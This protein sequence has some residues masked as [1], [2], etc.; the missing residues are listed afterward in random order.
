MAVVIGGAILA[1][2]IG[3][4]HAPFV[5]DDFSSITANRSIRSLV[6]IRDVLIYGHDE[7]RTIDGRPLLN[8]AL[9]SIVRSQDRR[10][11][12]FGRQTC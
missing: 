2:Y 6:P 3:G 12:A 5:M 10:R 4:L 9:A 8:L 1:A 7:G 11:R